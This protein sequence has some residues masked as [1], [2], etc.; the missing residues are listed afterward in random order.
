MH[1]RRICADTGRCYLLPPR[2]WVGRREVR[3]RVEPCK[4]NQQ[5]RINWASDFEFAA[6]LGPQGAV[7]QLGERQRGTLE[8]TGSNP[9]GSII[10]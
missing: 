9:V 7:A 2:M 4:N 1:S 5:L 10:E 8:A 6:T 3:L